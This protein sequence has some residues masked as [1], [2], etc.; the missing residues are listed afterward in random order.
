VCV[1]LCAVAAALGC[2]PRRLTL[3]ADPGSPFPEFAQVHAEIS[4][5]CTDA[6]T[7]TAELSLSG[8]VGERRLGGRVVAGFERP[9]SMRLEGVAPFGPPA[10]I[11]A[12]RGDLAVLLLPR[13]ERV[14]RGDSAEAILGAL[15]GVN[16]GPADL[17]AM[18]SGCVVAVPKPL[19]GRL[20]ENGWAAIGL[21]GG[22]RMFL[23]R[24]NRV[25]QLRAARRDGWRLEYLSWQGRFPQRVRLLSDRPGVDVELTAT[26]SQVEAN[27]DL[28]AA[29][30]TVS[31]PATARALSLEELRAEG[32]LRTQ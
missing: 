30:F 2:A 9:A 14:L 31:T 12:T 24:Q 13:D 4:S 5:A 20:H 27:V 7:L 19:D 8:R 26:L 29:A 17:Q 28:D 23:R 6:R 18:L 32:P 3:P 16:V 11:L 22:A 1:V 15:T 25:W 21:E 10:F